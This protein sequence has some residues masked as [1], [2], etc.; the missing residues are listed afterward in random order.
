V[1]IA[2]RFVDCV[3]GGDRWKKT[4]KKRASSGP[5]CGFYDHNS[6]IKEKA[7]YCG[8]KTVWNREAPK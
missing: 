4:R 7:R 5:K 6:E 2:T 3:C 8:E 1:L